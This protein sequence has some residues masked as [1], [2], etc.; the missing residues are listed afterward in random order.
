[1]ARAGWHKAGMNGTLALS[2]PVS[3]ASNAYV[4][5]APFLASYLSATETP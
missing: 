2:P 3:C 5:R 1:L 4:L